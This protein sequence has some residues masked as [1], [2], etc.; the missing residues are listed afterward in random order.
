MTVAITARRS[1]VPA[2]AVARVFQNAVLSPRWTKQPE[3]AASPP[4]LV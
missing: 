1:A 3:G 4:W 2:T